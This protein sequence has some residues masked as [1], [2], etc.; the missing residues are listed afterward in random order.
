[1]ITRSLS[2]TLCLAALLCPVSIPAEQ[3]FAET[4]VAFE[5]LSHGEA[6]ICYAIIVVPD[7][8]Q[9]AP[10]AVDLRFTAP[11]TG[12]F[13]KLTLGSI[14]LWPTLPTDW[15][16]VLDPERTQTGLF[17]P[18]E[19][20]TDYHAEIGGLFMDGIEAGDEAALVLAYECGDVDCH[21]TRLIE[22]A[23]LRF[24]VEEQDSP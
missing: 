21:C 17:F 5:E 13:G 19:E 7:G 22:N 2:L 11:C 14:S 20:D 4:A 24:S 12:A 3:Q 16:L 6:R 9:P 1:M 8:V 18:L 15:D 23:V 10:K